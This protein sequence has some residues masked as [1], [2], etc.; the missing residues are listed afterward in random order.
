[1]SN[2]NIKTPGVYI[3]EINAFPNSVV[4]VPTAIPAFIGYTPQA[5]YQGT[6][7]LNKPVKISSFA[8]FQSIFCYPNPTTPSDIVKQYSPQYYLVEQNTPIDD[9][10]IEINSNYY[11]VLP[12]PN[13][14]YYL[15]NSIRLFYANGG[16]D[17]YIVSVGTYGNPS[18][19]PIKKEEQIVNPNVKLN[20]LI[21]G[22][23]LLKNE[24]EPTLYICPEA[25]LLS[26]EDNENLM[27]KMLLQCSEMQTAISLFDIICDKKPTANNYKDSIALFRNSIGLN[28]LKYGAAYYPF[29]GTT[30]T[31][32]QEI[33]YTNLFNGDFKKLKP[34]LI[35]SGNPNPQLELIIENI[36]NPSSTSFNISSLNN[37]LLTVSKTYSNIIEHVLNDV[38]LLPSS[39]AIAG[40]ITTVD[41][42]EGVWKAP[43]NK[44]INN[45]STLPIYLT[46]DEQAPLNVD[47]S[48]GKS[49]N[50][51]RSFT[52]KGILIWGAR[53]LDGNSHD[54]RYLSVRRTM[55]FLEQ[56]CKLAAQAYVFS[57]NDKNTWTAVKA[58]IS[59]FLN[60]I[61]RQGGLVGAK[62]SH[63]YSV[64]CGLGETMTAQD[65]LEGRLVVSINVALIRPAEFMV[66][67][68]QQNMATS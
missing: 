27:Q 16:G 34:L 28:H 17:A 59:N 18:G 13:T 42:N 39:G 64:Q 40:V 65:I 55:I 52:G 38:N 43:A 12:D 24:Q 30:I 6:S 58:I 26:V 53:T 48:S 25:T 50:V 1:M 66:L 14:V 29:L 45:V 32:N 36:E 33:D 10:F 60:G 22:L 61:W 23:S 4:P 19:E 41:N 9:N 54:W 8:D 57:P 67:T 21:N 63:A 44:S 68:F 11:A 20:E 47:A 37:S 31:T 3:D 46:S 56:S 7:Y 35:S 15:Y 51:I 2:E 5:N 62:A 49:I